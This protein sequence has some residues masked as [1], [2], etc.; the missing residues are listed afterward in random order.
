ME[1]ELVRN[2]VGRYLGIGWLLCPLF[3]VKTPWTSLLRFRFRTTFASSRESTWTRAV[4]ESAAGVTV[5]VIRCRR[6]RDVIDELLGDNNTVIIGS[7][8]YCAY[9]HLPLWMGQPIR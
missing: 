6:A 9:G 1:K 5:F 3:P 2:G 7:D 8:R 4:G